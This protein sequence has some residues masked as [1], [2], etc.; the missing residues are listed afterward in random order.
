MKTSSQAGPGCRL[1]LVDDDSD[2]HDLV[3]GMLKSENVELVSIVDGDHALAVAQRVQPELIL[4]D[5]EMPGANGIEVLGKLRCGGIAETTPVVFITG[6]DDHR[7]LTACF[8]A[9]AADYI[10]KPFCA[11]ELRAR[12]RSVLDRKH[13]LGQLE[14]LALHDALTDLCN[15]R[16]IRDRIQSAIDRAQSSH[17]AVFF[18]DCDGFKLVND[19][20]GHDVGDTLL[21]QIADRLRGTLRNNDRVGCPAGRSTAARLG[22]DEFVVLLEDL[23][24][25]NDAVIVAERLLTTLAEAYELAGGYVCCTASIGVVDSLRPYATPDE[26]LR[27]ADSAM[28][29]AKSAG[30]G[31]YVVFNQE[32]LADAEDRHRTPG[33]SKTARTLRARSSGVNGFCKNDVSESRIP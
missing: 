30:T 10:R 29:A 27:D 5:Y 31:R 26:V 18:L 13:M 7:I 15:R 17:G 9:G 2:I 14:R 23:Y 28:Y 11:P 22:G 24:D 3:A 19:S 12:V 4:L 6:T 32:L 33:R 16:S 20:L 1:L 8:Q 21:Q 25:P